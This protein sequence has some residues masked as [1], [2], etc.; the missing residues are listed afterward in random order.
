MHMGR[1]VCEYLCDSV[2]ISKLNEVQP[3]FEPLDGRHVYPPGRGS[4]GP[5]KSRSA[6]SKATDCRF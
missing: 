5:Q 2:T 1:L 6:P 3:Y 4:D